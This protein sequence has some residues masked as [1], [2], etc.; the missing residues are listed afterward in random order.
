MSNEN[1]LVQF[2]CVDFDIVINAFI[3]TQI[4][5]NIIFGKRYP[6]RDA[7]SL[8]DS[9]KLTTSHKVVDMAKYIFP[10]TFT[11][12]IHKVEEYFYYI[13]QLETS[14]VNGVIY[15]IILNYI[16]IFIIK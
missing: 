11:T 16:F 12:V 10:F 3:T 15:L 14:H 13:G 7:S 8:L 5:A 9:N 6:E 2:V 1:H 4:L